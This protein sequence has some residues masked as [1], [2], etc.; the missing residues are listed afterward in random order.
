MA[1]VAFHQRAN[2]AKIEKL[3]SVDKVVFMGQSNM[4]IG[5][6]TRIGL[7]E[8]T[9]LEFASL[10]SELGHFALARRALAAAEHV[11]VHLG[12]CFCATLRDKFV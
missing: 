2:L 6:S 7:D 5:S 1:F 4:T 8:L 10:L 3:M 11:F 9:E 12:F